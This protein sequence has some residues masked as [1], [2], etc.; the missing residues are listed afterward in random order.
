ML[1]FSFFQR[2]RH[3]KLKK[4]SHLQLAKH[5]FQMLKNSQL[6]IIIQ[7]LVIMLMSDCIKG[8]RQGL[9]KGGA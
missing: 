5:S 6:A 8:H 9:S 1:Y 2:D 4:Y 3:T 7:L